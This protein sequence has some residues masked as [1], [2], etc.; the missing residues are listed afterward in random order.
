MMNPFNVKFIGQ[1][2]PAVKVPT[3][4]MFL[5]KQAAMDIPFNQ[6]RMVEAK[7]MDAAIAWVGD[8]L[9]IEPLGQRD[10]KTG[11]LMITPKAQYFAGAV[12]PPI[13]KAQ[14]LGYGLTGGL[15]GG[16]ESYQERT[17]TSWLNE[18]G[19]PLRQIGEDQQRSEAINRQFEMKDFAKWLEK[20]D[21]IRKK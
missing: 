5:N 1:L 18:I 13:S 11:T 7:G 14:R 17:L 8:K 20:Q 12:A 15:T 2:N 16:K 19:I 6:E 21:K 10:P 9:N 3:E 4:L